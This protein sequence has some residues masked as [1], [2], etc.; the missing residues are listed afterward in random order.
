MDNFW[1]A[2]FATIGCALIGVIAT[3]GVAYGDPEGFRE[4][5]LSFV[6]LA[7]LPLT[8]LLAWCAY[9]ERPKR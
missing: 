8:M 9:Q 6:S 7:C 4:L 1:L 3:L 5:W 2:V